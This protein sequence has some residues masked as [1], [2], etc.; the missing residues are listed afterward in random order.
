MIVLVSNST[1]GI[2]KKKEKEKSVCAPLPAAF[3]GSLC[4]VL[5]TKPFDKSGKKYNH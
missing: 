4:E 5:V 1:Q 3:S 2:K